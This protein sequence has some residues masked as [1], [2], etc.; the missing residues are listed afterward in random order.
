MHL[1]D[2][3][4]AIM[5]S[6]TSH[7]IRCLAIDQV[8]KTRTGS[9]RGFAIATKLR[10]YCADGTN[11]HQQSVLLYSQTRT[12][13]RRCVSGAGN[14]SDNYHCATGEVS[15]P[16]RRRSDEPAAQLALPCRQRLFG[17]LCATATNPHLRRF[18]IFAPA[19]GSDAKPSP[20]CAGCA[21]RRR[22]F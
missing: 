22:N 11:Q 21:M 17:E 20:R 4:E 6:A 2:I 1:T 10:R 15:S 18:S 12:I 9:L 5:P 13:N 19:C 8:F 14:T 3:H 7:Y 16:E